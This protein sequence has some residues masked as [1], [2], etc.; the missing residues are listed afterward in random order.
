MEPNMKGNGIYIQIRDMDEAIRYG[1][2]EVF[3]KDTGKLIKLTAE[4][5]LFMQMEI[6]M[7][8]TG[9]MIRHMVFGE[10]TH[11]DGAKYEGYWVD[12]KQHGQG[13]EEWPD[14]A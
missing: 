4:V 12:D 1:Q 3:M 9:K 13:K 6:F 10:Y 8:V 2:M 14:G 5:D 7:M 11:T